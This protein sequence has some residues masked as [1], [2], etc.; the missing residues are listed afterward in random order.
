M[1][2]L[3]Q[4]GSLQAQQAR[5][6]G[7]IDTTLLYLGLNEGCSLAA[8]LVALEPVRGR[9]IRL[10]AYP[11]V[12][13]P[14]TGI[15]IPTPDCD[16][17]CYRSQ[18]SETQTNQII[19]H[20]LIHLLRGHVRTVDPVFCAPSRAVGR[21]V[22]RPFSGC[23]TFDHEREFEAEYSGT[24]LATKLDVI[25]TWSQRQVIQ[26]CRALSALHRYLQPLAPDV[27]LTRDPMLLS[28]GSGPDRFVL[29]RMLAEI[30]DA[31]LLCYANTAS[32]VSGE[33]EFGDVELTTSDCTTLAAVARREAALLHSRRTRPMPA[34]P[35]A[36]STAA[37]Q[38]LEYYRLLAEAL[39]YTEP[40]D[41]I[42]LDT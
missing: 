18:M 15:T 28:P 4:P 26:D 3:A 9:P 16:V 11:H 22:Q 14:F 21:H 32:M 38:S 5:Y 12:P 19:C 25:R 8:F 36:L 13:L 29:A 10:K 37:F 23:S 17:I 20:E 27:F 31:R 42:A 33:Q 41:S 34:I 2:D 35:I 1:N 39:A 6:R 24:Y 30:T 7:A 40:P